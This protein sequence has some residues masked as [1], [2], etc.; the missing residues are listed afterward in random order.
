MA[1]VAGVGKLI[2]N[3][4]LTDC[5]YS[6]FEPVVST[7]VPAGG[8]AAGTRTVAAWDDSMYVGAQ[9]LVGV[10]GGDLEVVTITSIVSGTSFRATFANS[11]VAGETIQG[12][13]FPVR[14]TS[15]PLFTQA[16]MIV[17]LSTAVNDFLTEV[18]LVYAINESITV[19]PTVQNTSLPSDCMTP[20]RIATGGYPLRETSQSNLDSYDYRWALQTAVQPIAYFRDKVGL[21]TFGVFP[22]QNNTVVC[23]VVYQQ[24]QEETMGLADGFLVPD[25]FLPIIKFRTLSFSYSKDGDARNPG[26]A[27]YWQTRYSFG[28]K[29][30]KMILGII[31]SNEMAQ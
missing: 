30:S 29:V 27:K 28:V 7:V 18:P 24:R 5:S 25:P 2:A 13:T 3:D 11:H 21:Q 23:E 12:A 16:E 6:L 4:L 20:V 9:I 14:Q 17:Y 22:R 26:L 1:P 15:D 31:E 8:I 10:L 19:S